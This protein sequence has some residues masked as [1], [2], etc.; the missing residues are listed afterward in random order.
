MSAVIDKGDMMNA[1]VA[2][3]L[4]PGLSGNTRRVAGALLEHFNQKTGRCDP[5]VER[6][7]RLL[8]I[9]RATIFRALDEICKGDGALFEIVSGGGRANCNFYRPRWDRFRALVVDWNARMKTGAAPSEAKETV[10]E[11]RQKQSQNC[12]RNGLKDETQTLR[13]NPPKEPIALTEQVEG[14]KVSPSENSLPS[15]QRN[16]R[17]GSG[18]GREPDPQRFLIHALRGGKAISH[19]EA[20]RNAA[21]RRFTRDLNAALNSEAVMLAL[22]DAPAI[23]DKAINAELAQRGAGLPHALAALNGE[24]ARQWA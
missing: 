21:E 11:V 4:A 8:G 5:S 12:D 16:R 18:K 3:N 15:P 23:Y 9:G 7:A 17:N 19:A 20:A 13:R 6:L 1:H 10:S 2:L 22:M 24:R 14:G